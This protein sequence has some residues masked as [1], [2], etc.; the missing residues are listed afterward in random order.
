MG[1]SYK[2]QL[3]SFNQPYG[4]CRNP[5]QLLSAM[6]RDVNKRKTGK[7]CT[8]C[9]EPKWYKLMQRK[10]CVSEGTPDA[11]AKGWPSRSGKRPKGAGSPIHCTLLGDGSSLI[12]QDGCWVDNQQ[13]AQGLDEHPNIGGSPKEPPGGDEEGWQW[14]EDGRW[15][16]EHDAQG[17]AR[18]HP[19]FLLLTTALRHFSQYAG[20]RTS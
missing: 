8:A 14:D 19:H 2:L 7:D 5:S 4:V 3:G 17:A 9:H 6:I 10:L 1:M 15:N 16:V 13:L 12:D 18:Q 20:E 11:S